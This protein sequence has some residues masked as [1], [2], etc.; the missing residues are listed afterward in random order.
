MDSENHNHLVSVIGRLQTVCR[1]A[2]PHYGGGGQR[3]CARF[4]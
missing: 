3:T 2:E 1:G 4:R